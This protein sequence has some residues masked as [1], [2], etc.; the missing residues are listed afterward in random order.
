[1]KIAVL[2]DFHLGSKDGTPRENDSFDQAREAMERSLELGAQAILIPGDIFDDRTP[3]QETWSEAMKILS[4]ASESENRDVRLLDVIERERDDISALPLR[5][6]PVI[7]IHGNHERR[8]KGFVD[9]VEAL[10]SAGLLIRLHHSSVVLGTSEG[11][12]AIH[13]I[14]YAPE[15]YAKMLFDKWDP[16][17]VEGANNILMFHQG[18]GRFTFSSKEKSALQPADLPENFDLYISGHVHYKAESDIYGKPL[19]FPGSTIRTQLL[20][21][22]SEKPKGFY[23]IDVG[24]EIKWNFV[25]LKSVRDFFYEKKEFDEATP[26]QVEKWIMELLE[27]ILGRQLKNREK[28]PIV[29]IRLLGTLAKGASKSEIGLRRIEEKFEEDLLLSIKSGELSSP[30]LEEK[31]QFLRDLRQEKISMKERGLRILESNLD[32]MDYDQRFDPRNLFELLSEDRVDDAFDDISD[33][34]EKLTK[35]AL[36]EEQ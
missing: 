27:D 17:P 2:S 9:S 29:R 21:V 11:K 18:L 12:V 23:M 24:E 31:T 7:A 10:E 4:L 15:E 1:M 3:D 14:G 34:L 32:E 25:E 5:G 8:G 16:K 35:E 22:E 28:R 30:E 36:E 6:T 26:N 13:G 20:P 19:I 33:R